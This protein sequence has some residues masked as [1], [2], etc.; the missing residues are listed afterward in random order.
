MDRKVLKRNGLFLLLSAAGVAVVFGIGLNAEAQHRPPRYHTVNQSSGKMDLEPDDVKPS[1]AN[2]VSTRVEGDVRVIE[3]NGIPNHLTG[4]FPNAHNPNAIEPQNN[5]F[6][7]PANP[8]LT[9]RIWPLGRN[10]FGVAVNGVTFNPVAAEWFHADQRGGWQYTVLS[11]ALDLGFDA[12]IAHVQFGG[13]Y[14]YHG[15]PTLLLDELNINSSAHSALVGWS[16][17][18]FPIYAR[19]GY[20]NADDAASGIKELRSSYR[21]KSGKRPSGGDN[22]GGTYDGTFVADYEYVEGGGDLDECNGRVTVTP[23]FPK[24][25][26]AY[27]LSVG[28]PVIPRC[29]KGTPSRSFMHGP[30]GGLG[31]GPMGGQRG[32]PG[33]PPR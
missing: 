10:P 5:R 31:G 30:G 8:T 20:K 2:K 3:S 19:Y 1:V 4:E 32:G 14:H 28:W 9:G 12:N 6:E 29:Y 21:L 22:P 27:F 33:G 17:D 16:A 11:G 18:G 24:G 15:L 23:E 25:T 13:V 7:I 26:Y